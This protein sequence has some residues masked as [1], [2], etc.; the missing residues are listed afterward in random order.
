[1]YSIPHRGKKGFRP[2]PPVQYI[3]ETQRESLRVRNIFG[4]MFLNLKIFMCRSHGIAR[5]NNGDPP[6]RSPEHDLVQIRLRG[7]GRNSNSTLAHYGPSGRVHGIERHL[8]VAA[9]PSTG[10]K[11]P[12][13]RHD[14]DR[15]RPPQ[16]A[17]LRW[18][19]PFCT[20][21]RGVK[22]N[23]HVVRYFLLDLAS[24]FI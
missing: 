22:R 17:S 6:P 21:T 14:L 5:I 19:V 18:R 7:K 2:C 15:N 3:I 8:P 13:R 1:M 9:S 20:I 11:Y 23:M 24:I 10:N 16:H 4:L 12:P